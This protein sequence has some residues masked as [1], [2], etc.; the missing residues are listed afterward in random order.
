MEE[1]ESFLYSGHDSLLG[2]PFNLYWIHWSKSDSFNF[3]AIKC[4]F[5][6]TLTISQFG[7]RISFYKSKTMLA[8]FNVDP[9]SRTLNKKA[10]KND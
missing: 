1:Y 9:V 2:Y 4:A 10:L 5:R 8:I 7:E 6:N 3:T